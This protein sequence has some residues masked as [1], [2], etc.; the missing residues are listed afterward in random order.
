MDGYFVGGR[1]DYLMPWQGVYRAARQ[2]RGRHSFVLSTSGHVQRILRPPR[3][4]RTEHYARDDLPPDPAQWLAG[5]QRHDGSWRPHWAGWLAQRSGARIKARKA[6]GS[7]AYPPLCR[8]PGE[9]VL[10][11]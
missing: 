4:G 2:F 8:A 5:A 7:A 6:L 1:D 3:L 11:C 10:A 9:Y